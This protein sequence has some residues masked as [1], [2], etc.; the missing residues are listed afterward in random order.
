MKEGENGINYIRIA[1]KADV[2]KKVCV[3]FAI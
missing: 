3:N 1:L 2:R